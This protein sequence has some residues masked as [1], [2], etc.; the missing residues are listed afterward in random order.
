MTIG[1]L[2]G[3]L[4]AGDGDVMLTCVSDQLLVMRSCWVSCHSVVMKWNGEDQWHGRRSLV[5]I[6]GLYRGIKSLFTHPF[7]RLAVTTCQIGHQLGAWWQVWC[8]GHLSVRR[9]DIWWCHLWCAISCASWNMYPKQILQYY[10]DDE[11][12]TTWL[13]HFRCDVNDSFNK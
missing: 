6:T 13:N 3:P 10:P 4:V 12:K 8:H 2:V 7:T 11:T 5:V 1:G 9:I